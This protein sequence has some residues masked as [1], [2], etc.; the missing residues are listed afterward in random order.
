MDITKQAPRRFS[1]TWYFILPVILAAAT[2][3]A[4]YPSLTYDFQF[5]DVFNIRKFFQL[6]FIENWSK[7]L[8]NGTRWLSYIL[9]TVHYHLDKFEPFV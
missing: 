8:F 4:Y 2:I 7:W 5:D 3:I 1:R 9:N 6:R